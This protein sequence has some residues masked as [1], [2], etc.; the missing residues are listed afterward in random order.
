M[1]ETR[2]ITF[3][4]FICIYKYYYKYPRQIIFTK[5]DKKIFDKT[6]KCHIC[7]EEIE[8]NKDKVRDHC[9]FTSKFCGAAHKSC[10]MNKFRKPRLL[11]VILNN[12][13]GYDSHLFI[14][15]LSGYGLE[16]EKE[17]ITRIPNNVGGFSSNY[18]I[19][20]RS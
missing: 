17:N 14:K 10:N 1:R 19:Q 8:N 4:L 16:Q 7:E 9:H 5:V 15:E 18:R 3:S 2:V 13:S 11:P 12:L 20:I 6:T